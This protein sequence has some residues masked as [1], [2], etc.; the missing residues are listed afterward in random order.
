MRACGVFLLCLAIPFGCGWPPAKTDRDDVTAKPNALIYAGAVSEDS[1]FALQQNYPNPFGGHTSIGF[2]LPMHCH[3]ELVVYT[4]TGNRVVTLVSDSLRPGVYAQS[5]DAGRAAAGVYFYKMSAGE[6]IQ[7][8]K[9][10]L[11]R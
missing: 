10:V 3:V 1:Q 4:V 8:R 11:L 6:F 2:T 7:T 5:W 9:M